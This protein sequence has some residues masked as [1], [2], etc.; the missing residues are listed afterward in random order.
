MRRVILSIA[1][2]GMLPFSAAQADVSGDLTSNLSAVDVLSNALNHCISAEAPSTCSVVEIEQLML[3][4][5]AVDVELLDGFVTAGIESGLDAKTV[6]EAAIK[7][8][9]N[10]ELVAQTAILA[11]ADPTDVAE[12]TAAGGPIGQGQGQGQGL[13]IAP[14]QTGNAVTPAPF[15]NNAG[16]GGGGNT[17]P[18]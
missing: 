8:G 7:A 2:A 3:D 15:G 18:T 16:G 9:A 13:N 5:A 4:V 11:G 6:V 17:S 1:F 14:G 10:P 12:A